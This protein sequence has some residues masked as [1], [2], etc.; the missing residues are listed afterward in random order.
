MRKKIVIWNHEYDLPIKYDA[1][2]GEEILPEQYEAVD[3][4]VRNE[5][6]IDDGKAIKEYC[7]KHFKNRA[8]GDMEDIQ[9]IVKPKALYVP[10]DKKNC[11]AVLC[12]F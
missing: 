10:R 7:N 11:V 1:F 8:S 5:G 9:M 2:D 12:D 3:S 4:F 6:L